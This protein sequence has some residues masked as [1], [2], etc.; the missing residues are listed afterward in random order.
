MQLADFRKVEINDLY[1]CSKPHKTVLTNRLKIPNISEAY[2][3]G[4]RKRICKFCEE[5]KLKIP[6]ILESENLNVS[7]LIGSDF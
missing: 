2:I 4:V 6:D 5:T 7:L 3:Q 1:I